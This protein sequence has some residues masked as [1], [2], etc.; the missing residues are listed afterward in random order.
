MLMLPMAYLGLIF[1]CSY[2]MYYFIFDV[3]PSLMSTF[4][5]G[6]AMIIAVALYTVPVLVGGTIILFMIK[7]IFRA[8]IPEE[9][10]R[11]RSLSR[12]GE[13]LLFEL[14]DRICEV[15]GAP[16]PT[17][18][19]V[20][21]EVNASAS[22]G[23]GLKS[24]FNNELVLT[25]GVPLVAGLNTRQFA[26]VLAHEFGHFSQGA[27][28]RAS[29][30]IRAINFWF[31]RIVYERDGIDDAL[32]DMI[33][34]SVEPRIALA[35]MV[36]QLFVTITRGILWVF[37]MVAHLSSCFL[38]RQMEFDADRYEV[39]VSGSKNF[40]AT[41]QSMRMLG[42][43]QHASLIGMK[44]L[45]DKAI[46]IDNLPRMTELLQKHMTKKQ[47]DDVIKKANEESTGIFD[48]HPCD[49]QRI[50]AALAMETEGMF[51]IERPASDLFQHYDALCQNTTQDF[52]RNVVGRMVSASE[53]KPVEEHMG[54]LI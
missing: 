15:T 35:L 32:D 50:G 7:P 36:T 49:R 17:R 21:A 18:I 26:G 37:M 4:P 38:L 14:V 30:I 43:A 24:L 46:M 53:L 9:G 42:F 6:R 48:T 29:Y 16:T 2:G 33:E 22:Y 8:M 12:E 5:G 44:K 34:D 3:I 27:S 23:R 54:S 20:N 31:A 11:E 52:Y 19:N 39:H 1:L 41:C 10:T 51:Q 13:P 45:L 25:I 47:R 28:M 40:A